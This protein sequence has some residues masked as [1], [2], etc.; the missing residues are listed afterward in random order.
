MEQSDFPTARGFPHA[1]PSPGPVL[2]QLLSVAPMM[3]WTDLHYRQ[4]ARLISR[5]TWL[6]TEM[7]VDKTLLH[8]PDH[9][10]FLWFPPEQRPIVCQLGGSDPASLAAAARIV[11]AYGYDEINLNVGCPSDRV[12]G[13]GCFGAA[14]ML[15]PELVAECCAAMAAAV[16]IPV[17][18]KC[19]LGVDDRDSYDNLVRFVHT[20]STQSP[21][22]HF[23]MHARKAHLKGLNPHQNRTVPP[24][25]YHWVWALKRDFPHL[26]FSLNGG[27][28]DL[29]AVEAALRAQDS[30][31][32]GVMVGRAAYHAPWALLA[33]ADRRVFG[34]E[35][36]RAASRRAILA[37]YAKTTASRGPSLRTMMKPLLGLFA[38]EPRARQWRAAVDAAFKAG[39][40]TVR[41]LVDATVSVLLPETLDEPPTERG[42]AADAAA[43]AAALAAALKHWE[44]ELPQTPAWFA[45]LTQGAAPEGEE[46]LLGELGPGALGKGLGA[47]VP[48]SAAADT[49]PLEDGSWVLVD[50]VEPETDSVGSSKQEATA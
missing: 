29:E 24:L 36:N 23:I 30:P 4:L 44:A 16:D 17:T 8:N 45:T 34:A 40:T 49:A 21:V 10:R 31:L 47:D 48:G 5:H 6:Y 9:D 27:V 7:V 11:A 37:A 28:P 18:V 25:R 33:D 14:L 32:L 3:D 39:H 19:R 38:G 42:P 35:R 22:T 46:E 1:D 12:A 43:D 26:T 2:P 20:V 13:A 15:R 50:Q 41:G